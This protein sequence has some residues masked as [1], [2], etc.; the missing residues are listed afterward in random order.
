MYLKIAKPFCL[1]CGLLLFWGTG[2]RGQEKWADR[3]YK[4]SQSPEN[5]AQQMKQLHK[6][7]PYI[8]RQLASCSGKKM[9]EVL[10]LHQ[11]SLLKNKTGKQ[12]TKK[13]GKR[14][15]EKRIFDKAICK[16][17]KPNQF[18]K[19][20]DAVLDRNDAKEVLA[21]FEEIIL[22]I[23]AQ[24]QLCSINLPAIRR[25]VEFMK[26]NFKDFAD[27]GIESQ[28]KREL[29]LAKEAI[30]SRSK[31]ALAKAEELVSLKR[32]LLLSNPLMNADILATKHYLGKN[33][34]MTGAPALAMP[35]NNWSSN[36]SST[37][38]G[39]SE[40]VRLQCIQKGKTCWKSVY[41][42]EGSRVADLE[43]HFD[44]NRVLFSKMGPHGRWHIYETDINGKE[45]K[46]LTPGDVPE[47]DYM[48][49]AFMPNGKI[50]MTSNLSLQGVP[51]V[52]GTSGVAL[53]GILD[54]KTQHVRQVSF[55][56]DNEW[57]PVVL[58]NGRLMYL[59]W[60][61]TDMS[62]YFA[63]NLLHMNP[64]G[65]GKKEYYGSGSYWPNSF[66]DARPIPGHPTKIVGIVS[67]HHGTARS[68]RLIILDPKKGRK[69]ADGVV[70]EIP[71]YNKKVIAEVKDRLVDG[72]WPQFLTPYPLS[73]EYY[74]VS[75][76]LNPEG[77]WGIYLVDIFD[78][79]TLIAECEGAG[80]NSPILVKNRTMPPV[81]P[82]MV[83][84]DK[85]TADVY[86]QDIY[87][88]PGLAGVPKG[89]IKKLRIFS[90]KFVYNNTK[91]DH[92]SAGLESGWDIKRILGTVPVEEDGSAL[93]QIPANTPISLQPLDSEGRAVQLMRSW[94]T[95][96]PG[97]TLSCIG[98]HE[99][100]SMVPVPRQTIASR[101]KKPAKIIEWYG[102]ARPMTF[103]N[104]IQPILDKK[105]VSCH[106]GSKSGRPNFADTSMKP[107]IKPGSK[108]HWYTDFGIEFGKSYW[109]IHPYIYRPGP[110]SDQKM[111]TPM[112]FHANTSPLVQML[113][114]NHHNVKLSD[115]EWDR[116]YTWIDLNVPFH[117][118]YKKSDKFR[119]DKAQEIRR[120]Q[121]A[122]R[123][124]MVVDRSDEEL[125]AAN[126][127]RNKLGKISPE[128][129]EPEVAVKHKKVKARKW[130]FN[131]QQAKELQ[132]K[133]SK[134][135]S[136]TKTID[137]GEGVK[138]K[139]VRIPAGSFV[140]GSEKGYKDE[141][142]RAKV[143][144]GKAFWMAAMEIT[145][146][147]FRRL[148]PK[149]NSRHVD[150]QW[151][152]HIF[153][154]YDAN[155]DQQP[156][157]R[158]SWNDAMDFCRELSKKTGLNIS[159]PTESQWEWACRTGSTSD[160]WF[161]T[162]S[163]N[164]A[165]FAN[166]ADVSLEKMA[167]NGVDPQPIGRDHA[168]FEANNFLPKVESVNDK[169]M[170]PTGTGQYKAN[171]WG[172]F[173]MHGNVAEWTLSDYASYPYNAK[174]GRNSLDKKSLKA[175][176][177]GSWKDVPKRATSTFRIGYEPWQKVFNV[178]FRIVVLDDP[179][180]LAHK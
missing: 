135:G 95:A 74:L 76:K 123:F 127:K 28:L 32:K 86:I 151:K 60:E 117:G 110:E 91:G 53:V 161:G 44:G 37:P 42:P 142:P 131:S 97:E 62:H 177:G 150:Q 148:Y 88:G 63:R 13:A 12:Q 71:G 82:D 26:K 81:I 124:G 156:V 141:Y 19:D 143:K 152:D 111:L 14:I 175:V 165:Q 3:F 147:Q 10:S 87:E 68:G 118:E 134:K 94:L 49:G 169:V 121:I 7:F 40:I 159:L 104:E 78:N 132:T 155:Q 103:M 145:N 144:I 84:L 164:F 129:P 100:R 30:Y 130:P 8:M 83:N 137:L 72:V 101:K 126:Q 113:K 136:T 33:A 98:C 139:L 4:I 79:M 48:D 70:Q 27:H 106:N 179:A 11:Q 21:F 114:K 2:V 39:Q 168:L 178:G 160:M 59:R 46:R 138:I 18:K 128:K 90:Y 66:F 92:F 153:G 38:K 45:P 96:M 50:A 1:L 162:K 75:A 115:E 99:D 55:G 105:C 122:E 31:G 154:G 61:Y 171:A 172:L 163:S 167:V 5:K 73:D 69:E 15:L 108:K 89:T 112:N 116:L 146:Q 51:C 176:R 9:P 149:H 85:E 23:R 22:T 25:S 6:D 56:Q 173:D 24:E 120:K 157:I 35:R 158:V 29:P 180:S 140:M 109:E 54:P 34:R 47:I 16:L 41:K 64:D 133:A 119:T 174:D 125:E 102:P 65:T 58:N 93:F 20:L 67:G 17:K 107:L 57:D 36:V 77:L 166:M 80:M 52:N 170:V 43:L